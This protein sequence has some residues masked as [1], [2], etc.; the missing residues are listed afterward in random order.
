MNI[1]EVIKN[2]DKFLH[3]HDESFSATII[4]GAALTLLKVT[5]RTT[6]DVDILNPKTIPDKISQLSKEFAMKNN[7]P[8]N[9][10]NC[11][12]ADVVNYLPKDWEKHT[13]KVFEGE[14]MELTT[15]GRK[16]LIMTKCWAYCDRER[17]LDDIIA[18]S[19]TKQELKE[20]REWL[21]PLDAN[22]GWPEYVD[23]AMTKLEQACQQQK[24]LKLEI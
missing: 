1:K 4:G 22:P 23:K 17:D 5:S 13:R 15:L 11:G 8:E 7:L 9:W 6:H 20:T 16:E 21:K 2:F 19:P 10:L 18:L 3:E 12:P 14:S 24:N